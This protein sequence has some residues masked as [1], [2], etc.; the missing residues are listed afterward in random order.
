MK[1]YQY[2]VTATNEGGESAPSEESNLI[3]AKPLKGKSTK[4][5]NF[6]Y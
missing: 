4:Y 3:K 6:P 2:R 5:S 1:E